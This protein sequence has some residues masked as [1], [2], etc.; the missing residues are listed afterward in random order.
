[1]E[2][3][4]NRI[5]PGTYAIYAFPAEEVWEI[6]FHSN[7]SHWGDGRTAYDLNEDVLRVKVTPIKT[8]D[9][10]ENFMISFDRLTHDSM[11]MIWHWANTKIKVP[12]VVDTKSEM[13]IQIQKKL[14]S[15]PTAQTYYEIARYYQE[16]GIETLVALDYVNRA[17]EL[18]G[19]TYYFYRIKSL[20]QLDLGMYTEA[21]VSA[22]KSLQMAEALGKDEFVRMNE[23]T[24]LSCQALLASKQE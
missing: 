23:K 3:L 17:L 10:Q 5:P 21:I 19:E 8:L 12:I 6:V 16:Q 4:G 24:I 22:K 15:N 14:L 9:F 20:L 1:M 18:G 7:T 11:D 13:A 2:I